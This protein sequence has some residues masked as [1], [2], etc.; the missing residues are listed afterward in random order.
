MAETRSDAFLGGV[1]SIRQPSKGYR[2]GIDPVLLAASIPAQPGQSALDLGCGVGVA[3]LCLAHRVPGVTVAGLERQELYAALARDN[4]TANALNFDVKE[5]DIAE[6]PAALKARRFDHVFAN[7]P[8]FDRR[9]T[10]AAIDPGREASMGEETP[11]E[12]WVEAAARRAAPKGTVTFIHRA[13]RLP[14][15]L[16]CMQARLGSLEVLPLL[17]RAARAPRLVLVRGRK[18][19]RAEFCLHAGWVLHTG[20]RHEADRESYTK[21]TTCVLRDGAPLDFPKRV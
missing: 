2:A 11:L 4:A 19:G 15:L 12:I 21:P 5:G 7:P 14:Q 1:L 3:G 17:S 10:T 8:Y 16:S 9:A 6:M 20:D 13:A 18:G